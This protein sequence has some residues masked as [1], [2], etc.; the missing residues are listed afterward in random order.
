M[1]LIRIVNG[2][3]FYLN[4]MFSLIWILSASLINTV[5]ISIDAGS[6]ITFIKIIIFSKIDNLNK[7]L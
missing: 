1:A 5:F 6:L 2:H 3:V 7:I 4:Y